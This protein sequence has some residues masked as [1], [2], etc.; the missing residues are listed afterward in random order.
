M[1]EQPQ[2]YTIKPLVWVD[3]PDGTSE[4]ELP[5]GFGSPLRVTPL[6]GTTEYGF[7]SWRKLTPKTLRF[8]SR[9]DAK[10]A[11][12]SEWMDELKGAL[13]P[14]PPAGR[15]IARW[16]SEIRTGKQSW[17]KRVSCD[18]P[19]HQEDDYGEW[20]DFGFLDA[21]KPGPRCPNRNAP[22]S[23]PVEVIVRE[24]LLEESEKAPALR[25]R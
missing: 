2:A 8:Q 25:L 1:T 21:D 20:C 14:L 15:E 7:F 10:A 23:T 3:Y 5:R 4:A 22:G 11:C 16:E 13:S 12:E 9:E 24:R 18:C 19:Q 17:Q 6:F